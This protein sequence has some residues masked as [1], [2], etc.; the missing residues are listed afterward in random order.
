MEIPPTTNGTRTVSF[1]IFGEI[2]L[3]KLRKFVDKASL[4]RFYFLRGYQVYLAFPLT[5]INTSLIVYNFLIKKLPIEIGYIQFVSLF[6]FILAP[7]GFV[8]GYLD[9]RKGLY[10]REMEEAFKINPVY[11]N[12]M[13]GLNRIEKKIK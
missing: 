7:L 5:L 9:C 6:L 3:R 2:P 12:I 11:K 13:K 4:V 8:V 1:E 10:Q